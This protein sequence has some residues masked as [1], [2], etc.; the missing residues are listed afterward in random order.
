MS[1]AIQ[2]KSARIAQRLSRADVKMFNTNNL[3]LKS[4]VRLCVLF[5]ASSAVNIFF[6]RRVR[7]GLRRGTQRK[8]EIRAPPVDSKCFILWFFFAD[9]EPLRDIDFKIR[10][11]FCIY[12]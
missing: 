4:S 6:S 8:T 3:K 7:R 11:S 1:A 2:I 10:D 9:L 5:S 12:E